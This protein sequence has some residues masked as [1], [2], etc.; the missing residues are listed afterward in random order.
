MFSAARKGIVGERCVRPN[1]NVVLHFDSVPELN[2]A[3]HCHA[4]PDDNIILDKNVV[5]KIAFTTNAS[6]RQDVG[7]GPNARVLADGRCF[8][9]R[10]RVLEKTHSLMLRRK[11]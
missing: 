3:F 10:E 5:A 11:L 2:A 4:V 1:E 9:N 6:A 7:E 8:D